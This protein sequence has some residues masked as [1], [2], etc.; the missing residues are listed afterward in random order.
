MMTTWMPCQAAGLSSALRKA[1]VLNSKDASEDFRNGI[2]MSHRIRNDTS[3][4][5]YSGMVL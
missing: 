3:K 2:S 4:I 5:N 1:K